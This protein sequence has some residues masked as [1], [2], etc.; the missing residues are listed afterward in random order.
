[1]VHRSLLSLFQTEG[2][3]THTLLFTSTTAWIAK[4]HLVICL[5]MTSK[6]SKRRKKKRFRRFAC[7]SFTHTVMS[8]TPCHCS[9][10]AWEGCKAS[11]TLHF[12][13]GTSST[14]YI[15][16]RTTIQSYQ[17]LAILAC[18]NIWMRFYGTTQLP[19]LDYA[20]KKKL[21]EFKKVP[22]VFLTNYSWCHELRSDEP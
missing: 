5:C 21:K 2:C 6:W 10:L 13:C 16:G 3:N 20:F 19:Q 8:S 7:T 9:D 12:S 4:I 22:F 11:R 14:L 17:V 15:T 18:A 1:M